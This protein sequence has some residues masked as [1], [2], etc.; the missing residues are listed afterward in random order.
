MHLKTEN[1]DFETLKQKLNNNVNNIEYKH[2]ISCKTQENETYKLKV[3]LD[4]MKTK[5]NVQKE[6]ELNDI[7]ALKLR[8]EDSHS[9]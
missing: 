3:K 9:E 5:Y 6:T 1:K 8:Q 4:N 7:K 2:K